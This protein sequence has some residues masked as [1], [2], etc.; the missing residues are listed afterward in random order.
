[1]YMHVSNRRALWACFTGFCRM[2]RAQRITLRLRL[3]FCGALHVH[4]RLQSAAPF[5]LASWTCKVKTRTRKRMRGISCLLRH[6]PVITDP[7]DV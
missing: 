4:A 5:G 2:A 3:A 7:S 1:M 6:V